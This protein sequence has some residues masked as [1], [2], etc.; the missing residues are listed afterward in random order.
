M[1]TILNYIFIGFVF[2][3]LLD[4]ISN[5]FK[6]HHAFQ[7]VPEWGWGAR[8]MLVLFWP[9]GLSIFIYIFIKERFKL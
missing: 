1:D 5:M 6:N 9:I 8:I 7:M 3:F 4:Y 2:V